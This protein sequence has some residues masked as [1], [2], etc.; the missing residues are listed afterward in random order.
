MENVRCAGVLFPVS[1]LP[2]RY[3]IGDFGEKAYEFVDTIA[4]GGFKIWQVLPINPLGYGHSPYQPFSSF[5]IEEGYLDLDDL[6]K[7]GLLKK[8]PEPWLENEPKVHFE[9]IRAYK[10]PYLHEA[11][12]VAKKKER[13]EIDEFAKTHPWAHG[14]GIFMMNKRRNDLVSWNFWPQ[15]Q[16]DLIDN[17]ALSEEEKEKV[18]YEVWL[19]MS[20]YRQWLSLKKYCNDKGLKVVGD[21]PFYVGYDS[22]DVYSQ[23]GYF[24]LD[25]EYRPTFIAGVPPDYFSPT[26]QRWGNPIYDWEKLKKDN[27]SII[28]ER[29][30]RNA[31]LYDVIRIDHFRAFDT[32]WEIPSSCPTA[33]EGEWKEA[34]GYQFFDELN[35]V[36]PDMEIIAE[37]LGDLRPEVLELRD[38]YELPGM[39]V[40]EF[41][42]LSMA[43]GSGYM[44]DKE[45]MVA[46]IATHD[47]ETFMGYFFNLSEEEKKQWI[48]SLE[49]R[50]YESSSLCDKVIEYTLSLEA[51]Y[52][53][54]A[55]HDLLALGNEARIN[56]PGI[57]DDINWTFRLKSLDPLQ[58]K[59]PKMKELIAKYGRQ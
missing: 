41:S 46:Y 29:L 38:H 51:K 40:V 53:I 23:K 47:N 24:L 9:E 42:F 3:N 54:F 55:V 5:A 35:K 52:A 13:K 19:Q 34:P 48:E 17:D 56:K 7:R 21:I 33:V 12:Q 22:L 39:N 14:Y 4:S 2:S 10:E 44:E 1:A 25:N 26:G 18:D 43:T 16:Q 50:G 20:L 36:A 11:Y 28:I 59:M 57:I 45:N 49:K 6:K 37:D 31:E 30:T 15:K 58:D 32:Y 27:F 8:L